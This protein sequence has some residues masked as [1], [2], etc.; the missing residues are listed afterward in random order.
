MTDE[1][2][3]TTRVVPEATCLATPEH[4]VVQL[5]CN[6]PSMVRVPAT[7]LRSSSTGGVFLR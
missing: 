2:Q 4:R 7:T 3:W 6:K 1:T 5:P